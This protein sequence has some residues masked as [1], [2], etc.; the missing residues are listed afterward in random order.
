VGLAT[1]DFGYHATSLLPGSAAESALWLLCFSVAAGQAYGLS[2]L[3][4]QPRGCVHA[5]RQNVMI[6][7]HHV[8]PHPATIVNADTPALLTLS[9]RCRLWPE[10]AVPTT[11]R[12]VSSAWLCT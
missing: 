6:H 3:T 8:L 5:I 10:W 4:L 12:S 9:D 11:G 7:A 1:M 2:P